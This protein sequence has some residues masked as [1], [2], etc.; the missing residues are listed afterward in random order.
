MIILVL[1]I[2]VAFSEGYTEKET[3]CHVLVTGFLT[4]NSESIKNEYQHIE[5]IDPIGIINRMVMDSFTQCSSKIT[6]KEAKY[7]NANGHSE[8]YSHL[9]Q[10]DIK[11]YSGVDVEPNFDFITKFRKMQP[12]NGNFKEE[13]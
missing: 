2:K 7:V 6:D 8:N 10:I 3:A 4:E 1:L 13:L 5:N 9:V 11:A 12:Q